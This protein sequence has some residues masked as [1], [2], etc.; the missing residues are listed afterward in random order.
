MKKLFVFSILVLLVLSAAAY[1]LPALASLDR[2]PSGQA[3]VAALAAATPAATQAIAK[4]GPEP[5]KPAPAGSALAGTSWIMSSLNGAL[6]VAGTTVTLQLGVDGS[7]SG[8]DG[9][10]RYWTTYEQDGQ[11]L[12]F[13]QPMAGTMMACEKP[14]MTQ[15]SEYQEALGKVTTFTMSARQ[16]V[17]FA[18]D[19]IVLTS[20][21]WKAQRGA[22]ST[23]TTAEKRSSAC[24]KGRKSR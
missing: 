22:W 21:R 15:A 2:S 23:T 10:N 3:E 4:P 7:A 1:A 8:S 14:V 24:S 12:T 17:L 16:L 9:C 18:G 11:D 6:P 19:E 13:R 20:R 5:L